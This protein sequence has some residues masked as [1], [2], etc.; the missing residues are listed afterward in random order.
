MEIKPEHHWLEAELYA[1]RRDD[2]IGR[3]SR[4]MWQDKRDN[5]LAWFK[6][7]WHDLPLWF[8]Q[9]APLYLGGKFTPKPKPQ[10]TTHSDLIMEAIEQASKEIGQ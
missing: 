4:A 2:G 8:R 7:F 5:D 9:E 10:R 1:I 3:F 6:G